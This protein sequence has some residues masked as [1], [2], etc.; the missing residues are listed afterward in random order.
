MMKKHLMI[1][2][3]ALTLLVVA[4]L[5]CGDEAPTNTP[6]VA[7]RSSTT[8]ESTQE[9]TATQVV[10]D[11]VAPATATP[12]PSATPEPTET[13][14]P[15]PT[16]V[17]DTPTSPKGNGIYTVGVEIAPGRWESTGD[18]DG[19]YWQRLDDQ[20][21]TLANHFGVAG[22]TVTILETDHQVEFEDCGTWEYVEG[23]ER[24]L[25]PDAMNPKDD[26][27]YT[28][29]VEIAPGRWESTGDGDDCYWQR[30]DDQQETLDNHFGAA[31]G[32]VTILVSDYEVQFKDCGTWE[33]VEVREDEPAND[34][35]AERGNGFYTVGVEIA[36]GRWESTGDGDGCYWQRLDDQQE[37]L[38][39]H[40]GAAGGTVTILE[41]DYE[42][43]F[44][45]CGTWE[46]VEGLERELAPDAMDPKDDGFYT[47]GVE[48]APGRWESTGDGDD[49][50]WQRLDDHQDTLD[51]HFGAAG[52]T[53]T[54]LESDYEVQ[55]K[56][57]GTWEYAGP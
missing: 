18:G 56:D 21:E 33:Y 12:Q 43:Q 23:L 7:E 13:S 46:Y 9:P 14:T 20:Q 57:C 55:F 15:E 6:R 53:V 41:T 30:L 35:T 47:V 37:T 32:T 39:N 36:P 40:F 45:D 51:N 17:P 8:S 26:G 28:V 11:T 31:G 4:S 34:P 44:K 50:Y 2:S 54:I 38:A 42:V 10:E 5:A 3:I 1:V 16:A 25:T 27:F 24:D 29:G 48:I 22:G 19:C 52:G 49:C